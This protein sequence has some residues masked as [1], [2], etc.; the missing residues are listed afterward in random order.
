MDEKIAQC[1]ANISTLTQAIEKTS[2][3]A[4]DILKKLMGP[5]K[6]TIKDIA[7]EYFDTEVTTSVTRWAVVQIR[8]M[9]DVSDPDKLLIPLTEYTGDVD[10]EEDEDTAEFKR[11]VIAKLVSQDVTSKPKKDLLAISAIAYLLLAKKYGWGLA[12]AQKSF[13]R[14]NVKYPQGLTATAWADLLQRVNK[15]IPLLTTFKDDEQYKD[16]PD[17]TTRG[18]V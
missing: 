13:M 4:L 10:D 2:S 7:V 16:H 14:N 11:C 3:R 12:E 18:T 15:F 9:K 6:D 5:L 8:Y 1:E 17:F